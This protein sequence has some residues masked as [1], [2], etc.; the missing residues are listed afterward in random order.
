MTTFRTFGIFDKDFNCVL[1]QPTWSMAQDHIN[2]IIIHNSEYYEEAKPFVV[3]ELL[4]D[5]IDTHKFE[6][7]CKDLKFTQEKLREAQAELGLRRK[8]EDGEV[9]YWQTDGGNHIES[10]V[11]P[12]VIPAHVFRE[13]MKNGG[14]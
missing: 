9:W 7:V 11:C 2:D 4:S 8:A 3:K 12:V 10:L 1:T 13:L 5:R 6:Q 14:E